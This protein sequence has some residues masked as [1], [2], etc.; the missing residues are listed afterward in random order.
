MGFLQALKFLKTKRP[1]VCP[2]LG[3]ELQLKSYEKLHHNSAN[4]L[5]VTNKKKELPEIAKYQA[6]STYNKSFLKEFEEGRV[7]H[8]TLSKNL[9]PV[10]KKEKQELDYLRKMAEFRFGITNM[11]R[12]KMSPP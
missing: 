4:H 3:F 10:D 7:G 6:L 5:I 11:S 9:K 8:L 12:W 1:Q 2:N